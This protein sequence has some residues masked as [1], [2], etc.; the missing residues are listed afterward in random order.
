MD[1]NKNKKCCCDSKDCCDSKNC[2]TNDKGCC[3]EKKEETK[4]EMKE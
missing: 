2:K 3:K 1:N 4:K